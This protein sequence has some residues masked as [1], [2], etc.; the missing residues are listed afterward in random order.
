VSD[1]PG[2]RVLLRPSWVLLP[3]GSVAADTAVLVVGSRI[4]AVLPAAATDGIDAERVDLPGHLLVP[5]LVNLHTHVG[6]GPIGRAVSE[7]FPLPA[8][9]PFYVP[10]SRLWQHAYDESVVERYRSIVEWDLLGMLRTGTTTVLN[11]ASTDTEGYLELA[12]R[13]GVRTFA[14]PTVPMDVAHRL[15]R[16][17][18]GTTRRD[19]STTSDV[20]A[21]QLA[22]FRDLAERWEGRA[23]RI[24]LVL[25]PAA[26]HAVDLGVLEAVAQLSAELGSRV[27]THL[28]QAPGEL[29]ETDRRYGLTPLRVLEKVGLANERLVAAH[30]TYLPEQDL[31]LAA[32]AGITVVHCASRKA[33]EAVVSPS[34]AFREAGVRVGLGTDGFSCDMVEELKFAAVLGKV[35]T[36]RTDSPTAADVLHAATATN[37]DAL[38]RDDLGRIRPGA[39]ADLVAVDLRG[40][41][42]APV[43]DPV[44]SLVYYGNGRDVSFSMVHGETVVRDGRVLTL[45]EDRVGTAAADALG[46]IWAEAIERGLLDDVLRAPSGLALPVEPRA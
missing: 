17:E 41:A 45:D 9:M 40:P 16:L 22:G 21:A 27:T 33:K 8:G 4:E 31:E 34:V 12:L 46:S 5:G 38:G 24:T 42:V 1:H 2:G 10:L 13:A 35:G 6:A 44:Q 29:A 23:D 32:S 14:G 3:D 19:D 37:A 15:G 30:G 25:G 39:L 11:H 26:V 7:D 28:C 20:Q 18:A 43:L 36:A